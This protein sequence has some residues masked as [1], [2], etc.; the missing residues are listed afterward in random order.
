LALLAAGKIDLIV[1]THALLTGDVQFAELGLVVVDE[2]HRF[3]VEQ[4]A[5][6]RR[7]GQMP[8]LLVMTATP[9][10]RTMALCA[11]GELEVSVIDELPP[12]REPPQ[13]HLL[14]GKR[15]LDKIRRGIAKR[16]AGGD[17]VFV[18][19]PL[20]EASDVLDVTDVEATAAALRGHLPEDS[21]AVVHGRMT[22]KDKDAIMRS[23][24]N[25][26]VQVL[27]ATTVIEVGVDIPDAKVMVV[28]HA[29]RFGLAQLHQLRGRVGRGGGQSHCLLHTASGPGSD[30]AS[31][32]SVMT[33]T[34][35]GFVVA[36]RDLA[37]RGPGEI[38]GTRQAG[39]P[40]LR[41]A[42]FGGEGTK[43]L[44]AAREAARGLLERD[45]G[46][47]RHPW[48]RAELKRRRAGQAAISADAG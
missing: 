22:S 15:G 47:D 4:R 5:I 45:P 6:L 25:K 21:V 2:Q 44:V 30:V 17:Q 1:G 9:I 35:D 37:L 7:K 38:F 14:T 12:G 42:R 28:E 40:R 10:P 18:V 23:F 33:E 27:V 13:T 26:D 16:V 29:E 43:L 39:A 34:T 36:E 31:R 3:G 24:R 11:Y 41:F 32:L 19:C 46:L 48:V 20:V 8:H